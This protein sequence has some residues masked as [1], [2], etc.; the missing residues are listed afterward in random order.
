MRVIR[1]VPKHGVQAFGVLTAGPK[2]E[3]SPRVC[4]QALVAEPRP[5]GG[6]VVSDRV[7][8]RGIS[9]RSAGGH[10]DRRRKTHA[11]VGAIWNWVRHD[12]SS[13][14]AEVQVAA[15]ICRQEGVGKG[16]LVYPQA[17]I[18]HV[19]GLAKAYFKIAVARPR[20]AA[21]AI[22]PHHRGAHAL[23]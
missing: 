20:G 21:T 12:A 6:E 18:G 13:P 16:D 19:D 5:G 14:V 15:R 1:P 17:R 22:N 23:L 3:A 9:R 11:R 10:L 4:L 8:Q 7:R 2:G